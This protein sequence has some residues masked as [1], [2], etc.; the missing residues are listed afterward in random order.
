MGKHEI[1]SEYI[2]QNGEKIGYITLSVK[3]LTYYIELH[4][5]GVSGPVD[6]V[7]CGDYNLATHKIVIMRNK[8]S[9]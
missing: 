2:Y 5:F 3:L 7:T 6:T 8:Y 9:Y 4:L 1:T